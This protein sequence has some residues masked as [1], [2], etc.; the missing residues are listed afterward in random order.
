MIAENVGFGDVEAEAR[1]ALQ[2][3]ERIVTEGDNNL[4]SNDL[5]EDHGK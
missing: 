4:F 3:A 2:R 5:F 1:M